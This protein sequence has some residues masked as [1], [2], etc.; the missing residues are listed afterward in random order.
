MLDVPPTPPQ[1]LTH[2]EAG[3]STYCA[4][5]GEKLIGRDWYVMT[6]WNVTAE[7]ACKKCGEKLTGHI[8]GKPG[9]WGARRQMVN[10]R[11]FA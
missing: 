3:S 4:K 2:D 11:A 7:G 1:T 5:C 9:T 6:K 10:M 8:E